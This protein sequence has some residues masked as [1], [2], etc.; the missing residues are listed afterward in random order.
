MKTFVKLQIKTSVEL[1]C[2][3][4]P[5]KCISQIP[6]TLFARNTGVKGHSSAVFNSRFFAFFLSMSC[7]PRPRGSIITRLSPSAPSL[8]NI[9]KNLKPALCKFTSVCICNT[10]T[11]VSVTQIHMVKIMNRL[12]SLIKF[13]INNCHLL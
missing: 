3:K 10:G 13:L 6:P 9:Y 12:W 11:V 8:L 4:Q 1:I 7:C 2:L 5:S